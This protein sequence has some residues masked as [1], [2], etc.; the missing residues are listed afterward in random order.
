MMGTGAQARPL[1]IGDSLGEG[2]RGHL[3]IALD[4]RVGR[5]LAEGL[6][7]MKGHH[8]IL[9]VSLF[10][11]DDPRHL[12]E[13]KAAVKQSLRHGDCVVWATI[14]RPPVNGHSYA[15]ANDLLRRLD[16]RYE[17]LRLVHWARDHSPLADGVHPYSYAKRAELYRH[18][19]QACKKVR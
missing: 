6:A 9:L 15:P 7:H 17:R 18:E 1:L 3:N 10:T 16:R 13:L 2:L 8:R 12:S 4:T 19:I 5:P 11:N 14:A